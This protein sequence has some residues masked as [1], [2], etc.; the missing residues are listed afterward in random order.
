MFFGARASIVLASLF[1][2]VACA[3]G[4]AMHVA[5]AEG[6]AI[7]GED[8][9]RLV[10]FDL[11]NLDVAEVVASPD[12]IAGQSLQQVDRIA[13]EALDFQPAVS[14]IAALE[15][16]PSVNMHTSGGGMLRPIIRGL[17]GLRV[18]TV[19]HHALVE[20]Q[21]W[22]DRNGIFMP[23]EGIER[24][25]VIRGPG[26]MAI[27]P[28]ALG[29]VIRFVPLSPGGEVG[30]LTRFSLTGHSN[31]GGFQASGMTRKRSESAFH[32]FVGGL[33]RFNA[34]R[35]PD[36]NEVQGTGYGQ[37]FAQGRYGYFRDWGR[38]EGAYTSTYNTA[39]ILGIDG[40]S[41]SGDHLI[42]TK[43]YLPAGSW[44][45]QPSISYQLN[46]RIESIT[47]PALIDPPIQ[48]TIFDQSLRSRRIE[49]RAD[50]ASTPG[51]IHFAWGAQGAL[52]TNTGELSD[53][54]LHLVPD[55]EASD[56]GGFLL[57][58]W[59]GEKWSVE[60]LAR[61]DRRVLHAADRE[62]RTFEVMSGAIGGTWRVREDVNLGVSA[63]R[64]GRAPSM[65]E[66]W[67]QG[68]NR[69]S[70]REEWGQSD[71]AP[72][73]S[74]SIEATATWE[75]E[76]LQLQ[77]V[78][79][80]N[81]I[82][83]FIHWTSG[84]PGTSGLPVFVRNQADAVVQG[85][86]LSAGWTGEKG[87]LLQVAASWIEGQLTNG[88]TIPL[89]PPS[90]LRLNAGCETNNGLRAGAVLTHSREA[91]LVHLSAEATVGEHLGLGL[92]AINLLNEKY[93]TVLS[94]LRNLN[95][96]EAGRNVRLRLTWTL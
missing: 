81:R 54:S 34:L 93:M 52:R 49:F 20:S 72:E 82:Q 42:T 95:A 5:E 26:A 89:M 47:S 12:P 85:M 79:H 61:V 71:L 67:A 59:E 46:H 39:G 69:G 74:H 73:I 65:G 77:W 28:G 78:G 31:T 30:R 51:G 62:S 37:F 43:A 1:G 64:S 2:V 27:G 23:E 13:V 45:L 76:H 68:V 56:L 19:F 9:L 80:H 88:E 87:L 91:T 55:A 33:N 8:T 66:L 40:N 29:G 32:T 53:P 58:G 84:D 24:V 63:A 25:E 4:Q 16:L 36:G 60:G 14:R 3:S 38:I 22:G 92:S 96:P 21:A 41:Q 83:G 17:S 75:Q 86:D 11:Q 15:A 90:N 57:P 94:D 50:R 70:A 35:T 10:G 6:I 44:T 48:D 18:G 7:I